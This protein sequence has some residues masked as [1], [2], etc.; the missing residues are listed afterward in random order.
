MISLLA[1]LLFVHACTWVKTTPGGD[2][3]VV[4]DGAGVSNCERKGEVLSKLKS[5]VGGFERNATKVAHEL[6]TLARNEASEMGGDTIV[7]ESNVRDGE[8]TYGV[9]RCRA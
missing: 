5:R 2:Q 9:Y 8:K 6:E 4:S 3:V 1:L 7:A